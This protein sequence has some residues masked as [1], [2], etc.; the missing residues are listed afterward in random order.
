MLLEY[1]CDINTY[2]YIYIHT[3]VYVYPVIRYKTF[4][5]HSSVYFKLHEWT[6]EETN[7]QETELH[8]KRTSSFIL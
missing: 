6:N 5:E 3:Y 2:K 4:R 1:A 8:L 7:I